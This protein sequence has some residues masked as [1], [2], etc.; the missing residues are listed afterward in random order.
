[1]GPHVYRRKSVLRNNFFYSIL[2]LRYR[3]RLVYIFEIYANLCFF[4]YLYR[5]IQPIIWRRRKKFR[6]LCMTLKIMTTSMKVSWFSIFFLLFPILLQGIQISA[7]LLSQFQFQLLPVLFF[8]D[9]IQCSN[10]RVVTFMI[11][12]DRDA[13]VRHFFPQFYGIPLFI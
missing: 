7:F 2:S 5:L 12:R 10:F 8:I 13:Q 9:R 6:H 11:N 3:Y 1:M 4:W